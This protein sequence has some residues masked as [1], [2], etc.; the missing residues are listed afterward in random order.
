MQTL[1]GDA[2][3]LI[4]AKTKE[5]A[6]PRIVPVRNRNGAKN[7]DRGLTTKSL[8]SNGSVVLALFLLDSECARIPYCR[9]HECFKVQSVTV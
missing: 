1:H 2:L 9:M 7:V 4:E 3:A 5:Y 6:P 8:W